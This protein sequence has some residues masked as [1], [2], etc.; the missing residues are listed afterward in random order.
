LLASFFL[1]GCVELWRFWKSGL[2]R[3]VTLAFLLF[4]AP[5]VLSL[6]LQTFRVIQLLPLV[7]GIAA[8]G[9]LR[10]LRALPANAKVWV[11]LILLV[12]S[13]FWDMERLILPYSDV[14]HHPEWFL[15][16]E[17]SLARYRAYGVLKDWEKREGS[18][19]ILGEWD[20]PS[21]RTLNTATFF[22]NAIYQ[23]PGSGM[24]PA[25]LAVVTDA[26]YRP[27]LK[28]RF[29][30]GQW[31]D[32]DRDISETGNRILGIIPVT[33]ENQS[34]LL[35]W[36]KA[37]PAFLDLNWAIDHLY[38]KD[39]LD[40]VDRKIQEDYPL[41]QGD[42]FLESAFWEKTAYFY[43]YYGHHFPENLRALEL[44]VQ[45]GYPAAHLY[46]QLTGLYRIAG[47][48][49]SAQK[50]EAQLQDSESRYPWR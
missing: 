30:G 49:Q 27:F 33:L 11:P 17:K 40:W 37:N 5:G 8:L 31:M 48:T 46:A 34:T 12:G 42:P 6:N 41:V 13:S 44:A 16:T 25:W 14:E 38:D 43:Y 4:L 45:R 7:L 39:C 3:W 36:V 47:Q 35:K 2:T 18:G 23:I 1:L 15:S 19:F 10:L 28:Q 22:S 21:D 29:P 26:H 32:L 20:I 24:K 9:A 50:A